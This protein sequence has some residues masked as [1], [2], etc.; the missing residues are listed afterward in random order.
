MNEALRRELLAMRTG[1][2]RTRDD[3]LQRGELEGGYHP[4][5]EAVHRRNAARLRVLIAEHGW[6]DVDLAGDDGAGAAWLIAQHA[7]G[8]PDFQRHSLT[9]LQECIA[10][11]AVPLWQAAYLSDRIRRFEG[12]PQVYGTQYHP[13]ETHSGDALWPIWD[14]AHVDERRH[15]V[16]LEPM[17]AQDQTGTLLT[18]AERAERR[19]VS[20]EADEWARRVGWRPRILHMT[21][22]SAW[23]NAQATGE[24]TADSLATEGFIHCSEPQQVIWVAN[25]RFRDRPDLVL[26][27]IDIARLTAPLTYENL[28]GGDQQFPHIYGPLTLDAVRRATPFPPNA[29]GGF[30]HDQLGA[31]Y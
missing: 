6:P 14:A 26:L 15:S 18:P 12:W 17:R 20:L 30:D 23:A 28:E 9:L 25:M 31:L 1:D 5:M 21:S 3:L 10:R 13:S 27:D 16:G 2:L 19:R 29:S 11:D 7:A 4:E 24:Y 22:E 8:E